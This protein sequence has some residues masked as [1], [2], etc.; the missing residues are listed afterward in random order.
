MKIAVGS[1]NPVKI[2]SALAGFERMFPGQPFSVQGL[3]VPSGVSDQPMTSEETLAGA[4]E[5]A[6]A[7]RSLDSTADFFVGIEGGIERVGE[8]MFASAWIVIVD[9]AGNQGSGRS[10]TFPLPPRVQQRVE[11]GIELGLA[12]DEVFG[13]LNSKQRGGA[14]GSLTSGVITR[15]SLY[16]HAMVLALVSFKHPKFFDHVHESRR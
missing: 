3:A 7:L 15:R 8:T 1:K 12:N 11:S 6:M 4:T 2:D 16:E 10:G 9:A 14:V 5:R 13:E